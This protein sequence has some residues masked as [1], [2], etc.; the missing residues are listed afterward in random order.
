MRFSSKRRC[1]VAHCSV[2][3]GAICDACRGPLDDELAMG[4]WFSGCAEIIGGCTLAED[5]NAG[6][7]TIGSEVVGGSRVGRELSVTPATL[8]AGDLQPSPSSMQWVLQR[9]R[10]QSRRRRVDLQPGAEHMALPTGAV[11]AKTIP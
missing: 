1:S 4:C 6:S 7:M 10:V 8:C 11:A 3:M 2:K 9:K 5:A